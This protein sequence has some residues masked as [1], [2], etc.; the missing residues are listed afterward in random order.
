MSIGRKVL[1]TIARVTAVTLVYASVARGQVGSGQPG[2]ATFLSAVNS[3]ADELKALSSEK[4]VTK[5]DIHV[6]SLSKISNSGN[7]ATISKALTKN[8]A[9]IEQLRASL[10][11]NPAIVA[12][13][14]AAGASVGQVVAI[15][16]Q[17]NT[18]ITVFVQ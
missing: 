16:V 14:S 7:S 10:Q 13:L 12:A 8:A 1:N 2:V 11:S 3:T 6:V 18:G 15:D 5:N 9:D 4:S 17:P